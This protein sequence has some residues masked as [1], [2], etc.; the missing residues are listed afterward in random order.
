MFEKGRSITPFICI[1]LAVVALM[2]FGYAVGDSRKKW[3][4]VHD[5]NDFASASP[6]EKVPEI[7]KEEL[8]LENLR[9]YMHVDMSATASVPED[10]KYEITQE[11]TKHSIAYNTDPK[12][13]YAILFTESRFRNGVNHTRTYV[14]QLKKEVQA[15][16]MGGIIWEFWDDYLIAN[17]SLKEKKDLEDWRKNIE[18][19]T[20]ILAFLSNS[21]MHPKAQD[22]KENAAI[23]YYGLHNAEYVKKINIAYNRL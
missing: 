21:K 16:G 9:H 20:A 11:I 12:L 7:S 18:A 19:T 3:Q 17:T 8:E 13:V 4:I 2:V 1:G 15:I 5:M 10:L 23:R 6:Q 22:A 14:K